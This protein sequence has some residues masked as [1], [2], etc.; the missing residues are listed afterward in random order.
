M[1]VFLDANVLFSMAL[2]G[3]SPLR[4]FC[5]LAET[6]ACQLI[7]SPYAID[8]ARRNIARKRPGSA[9]GLDKLIA[10]ISVCAEGDAELVRWARSVGLPEKDAPI[11]AAAARANADILVTGD[12][13]D[14][15]NLFARK[16]RGVTVLPPRAA[17]EQILA[18][19]AE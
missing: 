14:F 1:R 16:L 11:L 4:L 19:A 9:A 5:R 6:G 8:E 7:A 12:R 3:A 2:A 18:N 13:A 15:G 10:E 17:L